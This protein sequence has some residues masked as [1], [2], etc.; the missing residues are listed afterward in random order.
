MQFLECVCILFS[1]CSAASLVSCLFVRTV[2]SCFLIMSPVLCCV[3]TCTCP[4]VLCCT[5]FMFCCFLFLYVH[6]PV[7][8]FPFVRAESCLV[9]AISCRPCCRRLVPV[10]GS[11]P[12][13]IECLAGGMDGHAG[14]G[15]EQLQGREAVV[16]SPHAP[17]LTNSTLLYPSVSSSF[18]S[19][20]LYFNLLYCGKNGKIT[21]ISY[22][23]T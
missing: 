1:Y 18:T 15:G 7:S 17:L 22:W 6:L 14:C 10:C 9:F 13:T 21:P 19:S 8:P 20:I 5:F 3:R 4:T 11:L 12:A 2:L 23:F 16:N